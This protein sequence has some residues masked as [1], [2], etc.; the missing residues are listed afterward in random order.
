VRLNRFLS[1][2]GL[3]SRRGC[4]ELILNGRVFI[5]GQ[6]VIDLATEVGDGDKVRVGSKLVSKRATIVLAFNKPRGVLCTRD[7][8]QGRETIYD[9]LPKEYGHLHHVGR[10]DQDSEGLLLLTNDGDL[11]QRLLH[12]SEG[13]DK[14]Y[15]VRIDKECDAKTITRLMSGVQTPEGFARAEHAWF[16]HPWMV[17]VVLKQGL[18]RQIREMFYRLGYEVERLVRVRVGGLWV[19]GMPK[20]G[21]KELTPKEVERYFQKRVSAPRAMPLQAERLKPSEVRQ[22]RDEVVASRFADRPRAEPDP[23]PKPKVVKPKPTAG[24]PKMRGFDHEAP[25]VRPPREPEPE[26]ESRFAAKKAAKKATKRT[27]KPT[28][29]GGRSG[30][31]ST[32]T[33]KLNQRGGKKPR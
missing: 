18:K 2:C 7:D 17:H 23:E 10:L 3:G 9:L 26:P 15:E 13:V 14:E 6:C 11:S 20:G 24:A 8:P 1:Q 30:A 19:K 27:F 29:P 33:S 22:Q 16:D 5:N 32:F 31:R 21:W 12:P 4:E 25:F 28:K